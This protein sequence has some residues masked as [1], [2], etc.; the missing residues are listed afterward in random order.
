MKILDKLRAAFARGSEKVNARFVSALAVTVGLV[1]GEVIPAPHFTYTIECRGADGA[2]KW[3]EVIEN[4]VTTAG[5]NDILTNQF[6]GSSYTASWFVGLVDNASYSAYNA[7]D[8]MSS[9]AGWIENANYSQGTR[10][11]LTFGT[12]SSG[13][14][15]TSSA[16]TFSM[17]SGV[18]IRGAFIVTNSTKSGTTGTLYSVGDFTGGS[19]TVVNGDTLSVSATVSVT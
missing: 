19:R 7:A 9:H 2:L 1:L 18:T 13:S 6:K 17:S 8:T 3:T 15:A 11:A 14:L 12:A 5:K 10:P 4:L 16:S